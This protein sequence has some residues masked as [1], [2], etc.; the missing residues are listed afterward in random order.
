MKDG[1]FSATT[2]KTIYDD[3]NILW[4]DFDNVSIEYCNREANQVAHD[5]AK[6]SFISRNSC[7]WVNEPPSFIISKLANDVIVLYDQ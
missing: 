5:L 2:S 1:G 4:S 6:N 7:T 3:Y